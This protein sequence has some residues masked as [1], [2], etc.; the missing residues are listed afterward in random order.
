MRV[1]RGDGKEPSVRGCNRTILFLGDINMGT[2]PS[3]LGESQELRI[4]YDALWCEKLLK[5][6]IL[7]MLWKDKIAR[8]TVELA[9]YSFQR[10]NV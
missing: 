3:R 7:K 2:W 1:V 4:E 10:M 6:V 5:I 8:E 9:T